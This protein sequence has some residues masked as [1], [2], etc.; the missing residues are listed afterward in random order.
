MSAETGFENEEQTGKKGKKGNK[1]PFFVTRNVLIAIGGL[2]GLW[3]LFSMPAWFMQTNP[4][5]IAEPEW[6]SPRTREL[7]RRACYDCHSNETRWPLYSRIAPVAYTLASNVQE[8][9]EH[10][11]FSEWGAAQ[12]STLLTTEE[13]DDIAQVLLTLLAVEP[14]TA[15]ANGDEDEDD[16]DDEDEEEEREEEEREEEEREEEEREEE[17]GEEHE[18]GEL[19]EE[20]IEEMVEGSMPPSEYL[21][22]HPEARLTSE[23]KQELIDGIRATFR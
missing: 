19:A 12:G 22:M 5:V 18:A 10:L 15:Y 11:N 4:P 21:S 2:L 7:A 14:S 1:R 16:E 17:E 8:G 6:D 13:D 3:L 9:R 23:E 20:M